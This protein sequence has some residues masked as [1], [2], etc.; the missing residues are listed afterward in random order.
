MSALSLVSTDVGTPSTPVATAAAVQIHLEDV[1]ASSRRLWLRGRVVG[2]ERPCAVNGRQWWHPWRP[3]P[4]PAA[5]APLVRVVTKIGGSTLEKEVALFP[6]GRFEAQWEVTLPPARRGWRVARNRLTFG[7]QRFDICNLVLTPPDN[8]ARV[9]VVALPPRATLVPGQLPGLANS[10]FA[11]ALARQLREWESAGGG[12][13]QVY[14]L[15]C[16]APAA[17][18]SAA[19]MALATTALGWPTGTFVLL[20]TQDGNPQAT[21]DQGLSRLRWLFDG[22]LDVFGEEQAAASAV[23]DP[24]RQR[25]ASLVRAR[26]YLRPARAR[27]LPRHPVVFCHGMLAFSM[28]KMSIPEDC[29]CFAPMRDIMRE[30][31]FRVLFPQV[32][33]TSGV[34]ERAAQLREQILRWTDEPVNIVA[35]SMGGLDARYLITHLDMAARVRTLTTISTPHRGTYLAEWF[36]DNF[37]RRVPLL[38]ALES[39]GVNVDGFRACLPAACAAFNATTPDHPDVRYFS[40]GASVPLSR[41]SPILR[42]AWN[43]VRAVEGDNDG[44]VG[45]ASAHWGQYLGTIAADHFAQTPDLVFV[46]PGEDFDVL[47]FYTRLLEDLARRGF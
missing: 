12:W 35:H 31:G 44:M 26:A 3:K 24:A 6:D 1:L 23:T 2:G 27:L 9:V 33:P 40:Y 20:P 39:F 45:T 5:P 15:A 8:T 29:N 36:L 46:R 41:L 34:A 42:R 7:E 25:L 21:L 16:V 22:Q 32:P 10:A 28:L 19:E 43:I 4:L 37:H 38:L 17:N 30:R 18:H 47:G 13:R 14:Y 11:T